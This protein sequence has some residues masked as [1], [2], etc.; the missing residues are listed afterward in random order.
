VAYVESTSQP[1]LCAAEKHSLAATM[2]LAEDLG[3][4]TATF[5]G[6]NVGDAILEFARRR[7]VSRI[8]I[9]KPAHSRWRD[10]LRGSLVDQIV[11]GSGEIEVLIIPG[12]QTGPETATPLEPQP[13]RRRGVSRYAW[14][15][16]VVALC[17][18]MCWA[19]FGR[20][21]DANL[22][23]VYLL[24]VAFVATRYGRR[25]SV[26]ATV[27]S[28]AAFDVF[29]APRNSH[30]LI[31]FAVMLVVGLLISTLAVRVRSH[32]EAARFREQ[33]T[34][35]LYSLSR[36]LA[37]ARTT[38]EIAD[39]AC[40]HVLEIFGGWVQVLLPGL[41]S[42]LSVVARAGGVAAQDPRDAAVAQWA[43]D[44]ARMAGL[45]TDTLPGA[46][47]LYL[48]LQGLQG[49]AGVLAVRPAEALLPLTPDQVE[50]LE[51]LTRQT[52]SALERVRLAA[53]AES[54]R[55]AA[56]TER[57]RSTL[58]SSVSHDLR[59]PL[60][61]ITG[62]ASTLL[63]SGSL[64]EASQRDL[65]E[66][67]YQE[68]D[69]LNRL[70]TNLLDMTRLE[71][72][73]LGLN[74]EWQSIEELV[75]TAL[76]RVDGRLK[77]RRVDVSIPAD[78]PLVSVDGLMIEQVLVNLLD[79]ALKYSDPA[80]PLRI[81]ARADAETV[82][83]EVADEGPG[84]LPGSEERVFEKFYRGRVGEHGVG[85]G[86]PIAKAIVTAHGGRIWAEK[87]APRGAIF[88]FTLPK[89]DPPAVPAE[90]EDELTSLTPP[91]TP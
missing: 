49:I 26:L 31:T 42:P 87:R 8:I 21:D 17:T 18:A 63:E 64:D 33:R 7:N 90:D 44:H 11:R 30:Y 76:A 62:A 20:I 32:A 22:I 24:G 69:R 4:E 58:L 13:R 19:I 46:A 89:G 71:S 65:K 61:A 5:A 82:M 66:A 43:F 50:L 1:P 91:P 59:T 10:R 35:T 28:V 77:D 70:I 14:S 3:A 88:R 86:L 48:P 53:D 55:V 47:A 74:R 39:V 54:A 84:L 72:G 83:V 60:A 79:N 51:S 68:A 29:F 57:M 6:E 81:S 9:G 38:A 73:T 23:M 40:R 15:T 52:A 36:E 78:L 41:D 34:Q 12:G 85:L 80:S 56:E 2:R 37:V 27:L 67:I 45:G 25:P 75:G 16:L